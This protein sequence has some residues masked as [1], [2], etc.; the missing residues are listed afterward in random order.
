MNFISI[1]IKQYQNRY[2]LSCTLEDG[3][4]RGRGLLWVNLG[5]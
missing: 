5:T 1:P 4:G 2:E 3:R